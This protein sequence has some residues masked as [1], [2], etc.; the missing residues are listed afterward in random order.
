MTKIAGSGSISPR[1]GS[2]DP[3]P[4]PPQNVM[5]P[6][7]WGKPRPVLSAVWETLCRFVFYLEITTQLVLFKIICVENSSLHPWDADMHNQLCFHTFNNFCHNYNFSF[8]VFLRF[9]IS[10]GKPCLSFLFSMRKAVRSIPNRED[11]F[12]GN[13]F[14][15][16]CLGKVVVYCLLCTVYDCSVHFC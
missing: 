16:M 7:H 13:Y 15:W 10:C 11:G 12:L 9:S 4:D 5:D 1:H 6:Q 14:G 8:F 3:D 2:A